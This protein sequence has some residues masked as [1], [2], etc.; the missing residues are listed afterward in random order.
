MKEQFSDLGA[1]IKAEFTGKAEAY[2]LAERE[3]K[4]RSVKKKKPSVFDVDV[5][6]VGVS[7]AIMASIISGG[8]KVGAGFFQFGA[9][10]KDAFAEEGIPINESNLAKFN[11]V[12]EESYIGMLGKHSEEIA[13]ERA[14]GRLT[15]LGIQLYG[16]WKTAGAGAIKIAE[17]I[18]KFSNHHDGLL[19]SPIQSR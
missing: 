7:Q 2:T 10:V 18:I 4:D 12:F 19:S 16:G 6:N 3:D 8:I 9:M 14:I 11:K 13:R 5:N 1:A 17:K 15:E